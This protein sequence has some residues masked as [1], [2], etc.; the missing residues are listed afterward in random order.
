MAFSIILISTMKL[1]IWSHAAWGIWLATDNRQFTVQPVCHNINHLFVM[2]DGYW[3][4]WGP[5]NSRAK[6]TSFFVFPNKA[7]LSIGSIRSAVWSSV[8]FDY[9]IRFN[10]FLFT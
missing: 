5:I 7:Y 6:G 10:G 8:V 1:Y 2:A 3:G 4:V 9:L